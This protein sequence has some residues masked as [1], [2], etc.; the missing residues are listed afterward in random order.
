MGSEK[1]TYKIV[2]DD[3]FYVPFGFGFWT[4]PIQ[5]QKGT[6]RFVCPKME[7]EPATG[8]FSAYQIPV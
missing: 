4:K 3:S 8:K 7:K 1:K 6:Y 5:L 2:Q